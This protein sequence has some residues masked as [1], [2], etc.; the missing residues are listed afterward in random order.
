MGQARSRGT[1]EER[2]AEAI[3]RKRLADVEREQ[4]RLARKQELIRDQQQR[5]A[6]PK[7][8]PTKRRVSPAM[9][10]SLLMAGAMLA[11]NHRIVVADED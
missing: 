11:D 10:S 6:M 4:Q 7:T 5:D 9:L 1:F 3:E 8:S 2:K